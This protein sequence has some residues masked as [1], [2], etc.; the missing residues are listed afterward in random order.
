MTTVQF[1]FCCNSSAL[2]WTNTPTMPGTPPLQMACFCVSGHFDLKT[3]INHLKLRF[4]GKIQEITISWGSVST[5]ASEHFNVW[6]FYARK[7]CKETPRF[8]DIE[9]KFFFFAW[10]RGDN[11]HI[12]NSLRFFFRRNGNSWKIRPNLPGNWRHSRKK[13]FMLFF[14]FCIELG[15]VKENRN[16]N[17][18]EVNNTNRVIRISHR[19]PTHEVGLRPK[20]R[21]TD[22]GP[23]EILQQISANRVPLFYGIK[24]LHVKVRSNSEPNPHPGKTISSFVSAENGRR[25]QRDRLKIY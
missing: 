23:P 13:G 4:P 6:W 8:Q 12:V 11:P 22:S 15:K 3:R 14:L 21:C 7:N 5:K 25:C 1:C 10:E 20:T 24:Y 16:Q 17:P 9:V 19:V 2:C 18:R